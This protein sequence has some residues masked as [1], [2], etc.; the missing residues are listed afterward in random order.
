MRINS[1]TIDGYGVWTGLRV[2]RLAEGLSVL[3]GPNEAGKTTLLAFIRGVLYGFAGSGGRYLPPLRGGQPGGG[4]ELTGSHGQFLLQRHVEQAAEGGIRDELALTAADGTQQGEPRLK[5][6]L[7]NI[8]EAVFRNVFAVGLREIQELATLSDSRAAELLY[9]LTAGLDRVSLVE[10][11]REL[12]SSRNRLLDRNGQ[13]CLIAE[14]VEERTR[15]K[16][17]IEQLATGTRHYIRLAA[18]RDQIEQDIHIHEEQQA[19]IEQHAR[20]VELASNLQSRWEQR[21]ELKGQLASLAPVAALPEDAVERLDAIVSRLSSRQRQV[22]ELAARR[23]QL[24][25]EVDSLA[26][27]RGLWRQGARIE[28]LVEQQAWIESLD[29]NIGEL[30]SEVASLEGTIRRER[31]ALGF[32]GDVP[33]DAPLR[34]SHQTVKRLRSPASAVRAARQRVAEAREQLAIAQEELETLDRETK[35]AFS[36]RN[37]NELAGV[38]DEAGAR[39]AQ[40]RRRLLVD[41]RL[42]EL[43]RYQSDLEEQSRESLQKQVLPVWVVMAFGAC[44]ALGVVL[45]VAGLF[46]PASVTGS[47]GWAMTILGLLGASAAGFGKVLLERSNARQL[48]SCQRQVIMLDAQIRQAEEERDT[49]DAQ[50]PQGGGPIS[51]RL[52]TAE[53]ELAALEDLVPMRGKRDAARQRVDAAARRLAESEGDLTAARRRFSESLVE[54]GL[55]PK[56]GLKQVRRVVAQCEQHGELF[57]QMQR[58]REELNSRRRELETIAGRIRDLAEEAEIST[59]RTTPLAVLTQLD[60]A[61]GRQRNRVE[62]YRELRREA[63]QL[64]R[65]Y[66]KHV[67]AISRLKHH[68]RALFLEAGVEEEQ[69]LRELAVQA[70]RAAVLRQERD[71]LT[72]EIEAATAGTCTVEAIGQELEAG[73]L[74][75]RLEQLFVQLDATE[76]RLKELFERRGQLGEQLRSLAADRQLARRQLDLATVETR[77]HEAI[78]RWQVFAVTSHVLDAIRI[79]YERDRQPET[80]QE[81]SGYLKRLTRG[82]YCR[83]WTPLGEDSLRVDD[84]E[85]YSLPIETLSRGTREQLFLS[86]RLA[87]AAS[88]AR[89]GAPLPLVLD[90]VLVNFDAERA[91]AAAELLRDFAATGQQLLVFTCHKHVFELFCTLD[92]PAA[93]L[94][95]NTRANPAALALTAAP[96]GSRRRSR[97]PK[98]T[99]V[100]EPVHVE[101]VQEVATEPV[102]DAVEAELPEPVEAPLSDA[103]VTV[104]DDEA[105]VLIDT[106]D[107][108]DEETESPI[109]DR[110]DDALWPIDKAEPDLQAAGRVFDA[111]FFSSEDE[112]TGL[113]GW[114]SEQ[115]GEGF[116]WYEETSD[117]EG[118]DEGDADAEV[119][120]DDEEMDEEADD[121]EEDEPEEEHDEFEEDEEEGPEDEEEEEEDEFEEDEDADD[122]E[123]GELLDDEWGEEQDGEE[124]WCEEDEE[125]EDCDDEDYEDGSEDDEEED[126]FQDEDEEDDSDWGDSDWDDEPEDDVDDSAQAA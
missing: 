1:L 104:G 47:F 40:L 15:L 67:E 64:R 122:A 84:S 63:R 101:P 82:R 92:V 59:D 60:S 100:I 85:G 65:Q 120:A 25:I 94:P 8:D 3:Y 24:K 28:A 80:L 45:V 68:R 17:E 121:F 116:G 52:Q 43:T 72:R 30:E 113:S 69:Q 96:K 107:D 95:S 48:E 117:E 118:S 97:K 91:Q 36:G 73:D 41:D 50:L 26:I 74:E 77:L 33:L 42:D 6:L 16:R 37:E 5:L 102:E 11:V 71:G 93:Q 124:E 35:A 34:I 86:L 19:A 62:R 115:S 9:S 29:Q 90:D 87:L 99:P 27:H 125:E 109:D 61:L 55:P 108:L 75:N 98:P 2:E 114:G 4:I 14:L 31:E 7:G 79:D 49:L 119:A 44:F 110:F 106:G 70:A 39:V 53:A 126:V 51:A 58:R 20:I 54:I 88:Y 13:P 89:R 105:E 32:A 103:F 112:T 78:R 56:L 38:I 21:E 12:D 76:T 18:E 46:V 111:D 23:R 123:D 22:D 83:V 57:R 66:R 81:A 10:V